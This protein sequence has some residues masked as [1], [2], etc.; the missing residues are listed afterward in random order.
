[1]NFAGFI[2]YDEKFEDKVQVIWSGSF[3]GKVSGTQTR[4]VVMSFAVLNCIL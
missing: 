4:M 2:V 3:W 1:M